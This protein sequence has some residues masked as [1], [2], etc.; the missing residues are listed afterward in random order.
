MRIRCAAV[1]FGI[2]IIIL[3][4][5]SVWAGVDLELRPVSPIVHVGETVEIG[6]YA[7]SGDGSIWKMAALD[8]IISYN[9]MKLGFIDITSAGAPYQWLV[10]GFM[11]PTPD[12]INNSLYDGTMLYTAWSQMGQSNAATVTPQGLLVTTFRF[13]AAAP[14]NREYVYILP[15]WGL[16]ETVV[17]DGTVPN[18][19]ITGLLY[20]A[21]IRILPTAAFSL[22]SEM[23]SLPDG[24]L[25][26][27]NGPVVTRTFGNMFYVE[28]ASRACGMRV[29]RISGDIPAEGTVP[30]IIGELRTIEGEKVIADAQI[31]AG[32]AA[33]IP[34]PL[35]MNSRAAAVGLSA[36]G[37][38]V[39]MW[40]R[41]DVPAP[42]S[43]EFI[44]SDS[45]ASR[46]RVKLY[47]QSAPSDGEY[48][49]VTG[50]LGADAEGQV[51]RVN[52][53][54]PAAVLQ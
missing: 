45:P 17:L 32:N 54:S 18:L 53:T 39:T 1:A 2:A 11:T 47:G 44:I 24:T 51:L 33:E 46:M 50:V 23:K 52:A 12:G 48:V 36:Q 41:A 49:K 9:P 26:E 20:G 7:V 10:S 21:E 5:G 35:G 31:T 22:V 8:A 43:D 14:A 4:A 15:T 29:D 42:A 19:D 30:N 38:L 3:C 27:V 16:S 25:V 13:T 34:S 40:G 28:D 6:L 37:L